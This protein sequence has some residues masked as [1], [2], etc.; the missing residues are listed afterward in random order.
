MN[1]SDLQKALS[2][3]PLGQLRC[4]DSLGSTNDEAL[5]WAAQGAPDLSLVVADEQTAGRGRFGRKWYTPAGSAL[6]FSLILRPTAAEAA[7]H[8]RAVGLAALAVAESLLTRSL[9]AQIKWPNDVLVDGRKIAGI[10]LESIWIGAQV[11]FSIIG[12]GLNVQRASVPPPALLDFPAVSLEQAL[13]AP[14]PPR[15]TVLREVLAALLRW[16]ARMGTDEFIRRWEELLAFRGQPVQVSEGG[17]QP[18]SGSLIGL[19]SDGSLRLVKPDGSLMTVYY[20]DV[21]LR[22]AV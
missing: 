18:V 2:A 6:A 11:D 5:V 1:Q 10:L 16:R 19:E 15:E 20:G 7:F 9:P 14:P 22:P 8:S 3:L 17:G 21:R 12:V 13:G 4:F